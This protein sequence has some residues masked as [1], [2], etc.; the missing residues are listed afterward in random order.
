MISGTNKVV[1]RKATQEDLDAIKALA[2]THRYE[3]GFVRRPALAE[4]VD[5]REVL[6]AYD[7]QDLVGFAEYRHRQ[8]AQTTMYHIVVKQEYRGQGI[9]RALMEALRDEAQF[10][11]KQVVRLKCPADLAANCFYKSVGYR[12]V[13]EETGKRRSLIIWELPI[14]PS[15]SS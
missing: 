8:D 15:L 14:Q 7:C 13:G 12:L 2:D 10:E 1:I 4:A 11:G 9:G 6:V 3:L 5:R